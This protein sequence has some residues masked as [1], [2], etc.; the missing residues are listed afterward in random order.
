L[1]LDPAWI[2]R[3]YGTDLDDWLSARRSWLGPAGRRTFSSDW[4]DRLG[5]SD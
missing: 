4:L 1:R 3:A 2:R 5:L